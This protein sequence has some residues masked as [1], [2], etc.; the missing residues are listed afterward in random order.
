MQLDVIK[1]GDGCLAP[2][3]VGRLAIKAPFAF[4]ASLKRPEGLAVAAGCHG[5]CKELIVQAQFKV[6]TQSRRG[7]IDFNFGRDTF[8]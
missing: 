2:T 7:V 8:E 6:R 5:F 3:G 1:G 4:T